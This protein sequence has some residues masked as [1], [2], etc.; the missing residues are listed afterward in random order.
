MYSGK[1]FVLVASLRSQ[2]S[3]LK[4]L[5]FYCP[6]LTAKVPRAQRPLTGA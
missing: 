3:C 1:N 2:R 5:Y 6:V 4:T